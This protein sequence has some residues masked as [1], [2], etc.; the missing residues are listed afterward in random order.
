MSLGFQ[1]LLTGE[2]IET[3]FIC[4]KQPS[5]CLRLSLLQL[6]SHCFH[7]VS[8][9]VIER[10]FVEVWRSSLRKFLCFGEFERDKIESKDISSTIK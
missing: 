5:C 6:T 2:S 8:S 4:N 1:K 3:Y 9:V 7:N 10:L